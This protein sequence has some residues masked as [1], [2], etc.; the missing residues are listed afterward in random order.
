[1][2]TENTSTAPAPTVLDMVW[3]SIVTPGAG[4]GL[5]AVTNAA[6]LALILFIGIFSLLGYYSIHLLVLFLM[7]L[8]LLLSFNWYVRECLWGRE[9]RAEEGRESGSPDV[10]SAFGEA[11]RASRYGLALSQCTHSKVGSI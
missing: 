4:P 7:S 2:I 6:I 3:D 1:M 5:I 8:G 10:G 9:G 11:S